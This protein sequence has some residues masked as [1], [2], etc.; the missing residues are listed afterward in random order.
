MVYTYYIS[1]FYLVG[2]RLE[3]SMDTYIQI[4]SIDT[5]HFLKRHLGVTVLPDVLVKNAFLRFDVA[6]TYIFP[7]LMWR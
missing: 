5:L 2:C 3:V 6:P 1:S 7:R 4:M